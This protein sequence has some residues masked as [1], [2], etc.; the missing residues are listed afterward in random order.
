[1]EVMYFEFTRMPCE[2][3]RRRLRSLWLCL[4]D[5]DVILFA[6]GLVRRVCRP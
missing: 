4:H 5:Y 1:M 2:N 6:Q 3:Y